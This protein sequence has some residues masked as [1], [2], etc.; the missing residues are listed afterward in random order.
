MFKY[1]GSTD[2]PQKR[3]KVTISAFNPASINPHYG[4]IDRNKK[5]NS[6]GS[7]EIKWSTNFLLLR[8]INSARLEAEERCFYLQASSVLWHTT[9]RSWQERDEIAAASAEHW[10]PHINRAYGH[11]QNPLLV[12]CL[13]LVYL[14][15]DSEIL[16]LISK[17][18]WLLHWFGTFLSA[19]TLSDI[20]WLLAESGLVSRKDGD[21]VIEDLP[22]QIHRCWRDGERLVRVLNL[23]FL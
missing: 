14:S 2:I 21:I 6:I 5:S 12:S 17:D 7:W 1:D 15:I 4:S 19:W 23:H 22:K 20:L 8:S 13:W 11:G 18:L 10:W 16:Q 9:L 3:G